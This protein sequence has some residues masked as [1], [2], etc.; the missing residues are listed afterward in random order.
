MRTNKLSIILVLLLIISSGEL[1]YE[2]YYSF[3]S[4]IFLAIT[5]SIF[6]IK[7][8][9]KSISA[10]TILWLLYFIL[11][12]LF[13]V[14]INNDEDLTHYLGVVITIITVVLIKNI[15]SFEGFKE[16][17]IN[18]LFILCCIS[19]LFYI[20]GVLIP[21][22]VYLLP[23]VKSISSPVVYKYAILHSYRFEPVFFEF[24]SFNKNSSI[25]WEPGAYQLFLNLALFFEF[26]RNTLRKLRILIFVV[27][28]I[29]T[30]STMGILLLGAILVTH[31]RKYLNKRI[32]LL[33]IS[34]TI[35]AIILMLSNLNLN[36]E[37]TSNTYYNMLFS[38]FDKTS[39]S[40]IS[41]QSRMNNSIKDINIILTKPLGVGYTNY[42]N[43][44]NMGGSENSITSIWAV[45][46]LL[47]AF[48]LYLG[49]IMMGFYKA[50][51]KLNY[52]ILPLLILLSCLTEKFLYTPI[53]MYLA[54]VPIDLIKNNKRLI[55]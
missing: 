49:V 32:A 13:N 3:A 9:Y 52:Y 11:V 35:I 5:L 7:K 21:W 38:K 26:K 14:I 31:T 42:I 23:T 54:L 34:T 28:I 20:M 15:I 50:G 16:T 41:Y 12:L 33:T 39:N 2:N 22:V 40:Y 1:I 48:P 45:Y 44:Y 18:L 53:V 10:F 51:Q 8:K 30:I 19:L 29:S 27:G 43:K 25:F 55:K 47:F 6:I 24:N 37:G 36:S 17:Y 4:V 46:G